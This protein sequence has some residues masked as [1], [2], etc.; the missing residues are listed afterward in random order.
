[1]ITL[2]ISL[3]VWGIIGLIFFVLIAKRATEIEKEDGTE[4]PTCKIIVL[5][6]SWLGKK[7]SPFREGMNCLYYQK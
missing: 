5:V 6:L 3:I 1:M 7:T 4:T 2:I